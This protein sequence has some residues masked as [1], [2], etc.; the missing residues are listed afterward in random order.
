MSKKE[1]HN[2]A[3]Y[4]KYR[5][6]SFDEVIGQDHVV[7]TIKKSLTD[8]HIAHAYLFTGS[9]GIGKTTIARIIA[10]ELET[11]PNDI[12]EIDAASNR[13]IDDI[14]DLRENVRTLPFDSKYKVYIIDEVHM[15]TKEAFNALLKTLEE[16]PHY[17]IFILATTELSKVPETIVSRC[18]T[19]VLKK[20]TEAILAS[21]VIRI[22]KSEG[23]KIAPDASEL[24]ALLGDGS[25]RDTLGVLQKVLS[26]VSDKSIDAETVALITG[27]PRGTLV[28]TLIEMIATHDIAGALA[29]IRKASEDHVDMN[30]FFKLFL[31]KF[32]LILIL[33]YAP[34]EAELFANQVSES[35]L[36]LF[37]KL[38]AQKP[39]TIT[40]NTLEIFLGAYGHQRHAVIASLPLE[41]AVMR[42]LGK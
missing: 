30:I 27:A 38:I 19:Y 8:G 32:R 11:S 25:F 13:G 42:V 26:N 3:L 14:R 31:I 12:Y 21:E 9:R 22:G 29:T 28:N 41:L 17:V 36:D 20:P 7:S 40:S 1:E 4:R 37:K 39:D 23:Y 16:P 6:E 2:L 15:L 35:D 5:P 10:H 33:R 24:I 34:D 18:Q